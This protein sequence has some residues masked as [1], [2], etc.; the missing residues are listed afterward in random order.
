MRTDH[1]HP[2]VGVASNRYCPLVKLADMPPQRVDA[3]AADPGGPSRTTTGASSTRR[4]SLSLAKT[5]RDA[6]P[7][8]FCRASMSDHPAGAA[9]HGDAV[10]PVRV[11]VYGSRAVADGAHPTIV[12]RRKVHPIPARN[13]FVRILP[14][15]TPM[16]PP[17]AEADSGS[18]RPGRGHDERPR[19][20]VENDP[21]SRVGCWACMWRWA[22]R[23]AGAVKGPPEGDCPHLAIRI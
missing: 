10:E 4:R 6:H 8:G 23:P 18:S 5:M 14:T 15:T 17:R 13:Q 16:M 3:S 20:V 22:C 7:P 12:T 11:A 2:A 21:D 19:G 1:L 9:T